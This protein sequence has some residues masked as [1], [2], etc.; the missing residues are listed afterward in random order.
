MSKEDIANVDIL[1]KLNPYAQDKT[2]WAFFAGDYDD[3]VKLLI[4]FF[5]HHLLAPA[6]LREH[7]AIC[8]VD[9]AFGM[10][11]AI[12]KENGIILF[13]S[14]KAG[15]ILNKYNNTDHKLDIPEYVD[16]ETKERM[17]LS[18]LRTHNILSHFVQT[19]AQHHVG[20]L[21]DAFSTA[22]EALD[23]EKMKSNSVIELVNPYTWS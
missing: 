1:R 4:H 12:E 23:G 16:A 8:F 6:F 5:E 21:I 13:Y 3:L 17:Y 18:M 20:H 11:F 9:L 22:K 2:T 10:G 7:I 19:A 14:Y 15:Q